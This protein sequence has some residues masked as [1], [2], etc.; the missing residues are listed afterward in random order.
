MLR[1]RFLKKI[2]KK[3]RQIAKN[4][5]ERLVLDIDLSIKAKCNS[6]YNN[7]IEK[8]EIVI[9]SFIKTIKDNL[10]VSDQVMNLISRVKNIQKQWR[11]LLKK[12][13]LFIKMIKSNWNKELVD[14]YYEIL[15]EKGKFDQLKIFDPERK[16]FYKNCL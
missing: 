14:C 10:F 6:L 16:Y 9:A 2:I 8:S 11:M 13:L 15:S 7:S 1:V 3:Q 5:N 12:K 4:P